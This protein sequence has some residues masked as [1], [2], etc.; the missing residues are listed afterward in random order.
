MKCRICQLHH[1]ILLFLTNVSYQ[2][3]CIRQRLLS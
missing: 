3:D 2:M 1:H